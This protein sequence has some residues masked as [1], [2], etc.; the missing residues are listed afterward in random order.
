MSAPDRLARRVSDLDQGS[1]GPARWDAQASLAHFISVLQQVVPPGEPPGP[2]TADTLS[3]AE[4]DQ[5]QRRCRLLGRL[6]ANFPQLTDGPL[7]L[8]AQYWIATGRPPW[9]PARGHVPQE[10]SFVPPSG[11][12]GSLAGA[13]PFGTGL[14]TSTGI[15]G[16]YGMWR[17][18]LSGY[19]DSASLFLRPWHIWR[20]Q[21]RP[22]A[23]TYEIRDAAG[24]VQ[25]VTA[26]PRAEGGFL[27]P[28][29]LAIAARWD[30]VHITLRAITAAQGFSFTTPHGPTVAPYWDVEST[31]WL[32]WCFTSV[33]LLE[34]HDSP[35][36]GA[37]AVI[38]SS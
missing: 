19:E 3:A 38:S 13:K 5:M 22:A 25:L 16:S 12:A 27:H 14:F 26:Y 37:M 17:C 2:A 8:H 29:W 31:F 24:W 36:P 30:A 32:T 28:D 18:Y 35:D 23:R 9:L 7:D 21:P 10:R 20:L 4:A 11:A 15:A 1:E 6:A 33:T 34:V